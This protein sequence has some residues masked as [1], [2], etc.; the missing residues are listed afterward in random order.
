MT[1]F[2]QQVA[3]CY[4][5]LYGNE[6]HSLTFVFPNRRSGIFFQKYLAQVAQK[7]ILSPT[8]LTINDLFG[9]LSELKLCDRTSLLFRLY[10]I[11]IEVSQST[12]TFDDFV[13]W[14]EMLLNDFDDI[15]KYVV[16][17]QKL[18]TNVTD[19]KSIDEEFAY[20]EEE[21]IA[22][23]R[24]FWSNFIPSYESD[25]KESFSK[26]WRVLYEIYAALKASLLQDGLAYEGMIFREVAEKMERGELEQPNH[27]KIIFVSL[28]A[29]TAAERMLMC[30]LRDKGIA[31]FYWDYDAPT[32]TDPENKASFFTLRNLK[33]FPSEHQLPK[34]HFTFPE[35]EVVGIP[36]AVGQTKHTYTILQ[37]LIADGAIPNP[38]Q[39]INTAIVLPD[40]NLL[41]PALYAVPEE[42][43]PINVTMGYSLKA[44]PIAGLME[45]LFDLQKNIKWE[46]GL[47]MFYHRNVEPI[48]SHRYVS[49]FDADTSSSILNDIRRNNRVYVPLQ[50]LAKNP[51]LTL[52]FSAVSHVEKASVYLTNLLEYMQGGLDT[53]ASN[54]ANEDEATEAMIVPLSELEK[55]FIY[56]YYITVN[57]LGDVIRQY[58]VSLT[59]TTYFRLLRKMSDTITIPFRGEPL[60]GLQVMGVLETRGLDF[61]NLII[62]SMNEGVFPIKKAANSFIPFNLRK[63]FGLSTTEH[64]DSIFAYHFYRMIG[65]AKRV[66]LLYDIRD[67]GMQTGEVSRYVYQL[68]YHYN[69]PIKEKAI[70]YDISVTMPQPF[71]IQ[72]TEMVLRKMRRYLAGGDKSLSASA[73]NNY[74]DCPLRFY[75][76]HVE[77]LKEE[78]EI[79]ESM[80]ANTFGTIFHD[81]ME[82]LYEP[83]KGELITKAQ[84]TQLLQ[85]SD[86]LTKEIQKSF[87]KNFIKQHEV[88]ELEG[89][90][91]LIG[92]ILLKY[93]KGVLRADLT[94][95]PFLYVA[96]EYKFNGELKLDSGAL[97]KIKGSIDRVDEHEGVVRIIDYKTGSGSVEFSSLQQLFDQEAD[98]RPKAIMQAFIYAMIFNELHDSKAIEPHLFYLRTF[99]KSDNKS[100]IAVKRKKGYDS[101]LENGPIQNFVELERDFRME[102]TRVLNE[103]FDCSIPFTQAT[104]VK[105]CT[106]CDFTSVCKR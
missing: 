96:S 12:E 81:V 95:V 90:N 101:E 33:D 51:L 105:K 97:V 23:I 89:Y 68:K 6:I 21:Q 46:R 48:L 36:S 35:I 17:A 53:E 10:Q 76:Q 63:G 71:Q 102:L 87:A 69:H 16:D 31:D 18:F 61:E 5:N 79:S 93:V 28:N 11:F 32:L 64:Q 54:E 3:A 75:F 40:E 88:V 83:F 24:T 94:Q 56:H 37:Q 70:T 59:V 80:E 103:L 49:G 73:I 45:H 27:E 41:I 8:I 60:S 9:T 72:K 26:T 20:L 47:P 13:F 22:V 74:L 42:I 91:H 25:R 34:Q 55:E 104:S 99:F 29:L 106:Y 39:A 98:D 7:P 92:E 86:A 2:L 43:D 38:H 58:P 30:K 66:F 65:R 78:D 44:T 19:L 14:G 52:I 62:L 77:M 85:N 4:Y 1:P 57:R 15:D 82:Q 100:L 84:L 50:D 67:S